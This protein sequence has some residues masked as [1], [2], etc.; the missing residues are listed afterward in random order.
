MMPNHK[1]DTNN[2][3]AFSTDNIGRNYD[4][5]EASYAEREAILSEHEHYQKGLMWSL[6]N[7]PRVPE[8]IR[9]SMESWGLAADEFSD[10]GN[11]PHQIYVREGRRMISD[12]VTTELDCRRVRVAEDPVGLG[13][14]NMDSHNTQRYVTAEGTAQN[15]GDVQESPGGPYVVS[16]R[17]IVPTREECENLLVPVC[18]SSSHIAYGSIRMEP[19]FMILAQSAVHAGTLAID[20]DLAVQDVPYSELRERLLATGQVLD[21]P[22]DARPKIL[23]TADKLPGIVVDDSLADST[24]EWTSSGS[25]P[26]YINDGYLHDGGEEKGSKT[27]TFDVAV[28]SDG[29]YEVRFSF[30]PNGNRS[31]KVP[32]T[33]QHA[34]GK[35]TK[36][37]N[38]RKNDGDDTGFISLGLFRFTAGTA[39]VEISNSGTED[40]HVVA[41]AIQ[42]LKK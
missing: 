15:E 28:P 31:T 25:H 21:L 9:K 1:T 32:V 19:V 36:V 12:Y 33:V 13:S 39:T 16:Y 5:P 14:Y 11:W 27:L 24:G 35:T 26:F 34:D 22:E 4:F 29:E 42:F 18:L 2:M 23:I 30:P 41:D 3:G 10:N 37:I 40:G 17:S 38:Q 7:H 20:G 8:S 6:A